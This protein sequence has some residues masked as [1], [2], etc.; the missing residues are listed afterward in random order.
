MKASKKTLMA[1]KQFLENQEGWELDEII[2]EIVEETKL[3]KSKEIEGY[4]LSTDECDI[5]WDAEEICVLADFIDS[6]S[7]IFISKICNV[8]DSFVSEDMSDYGEE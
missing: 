5:E 2:E 6:Y 3:L 8:L 1:V 7:R 4:T